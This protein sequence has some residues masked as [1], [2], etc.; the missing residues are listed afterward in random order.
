MCTVQVK[1]CYP[2]TM[3][4]IP[5]RLR[6]VSYIGAI[7]IDITFGFTMT[8]KLELF[9]SGLHFTLLPECYLYTLQVKCCVETET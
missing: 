3:C 1:L 6:D 5:E 8:V 7:Q 4:A 2:L 9:L